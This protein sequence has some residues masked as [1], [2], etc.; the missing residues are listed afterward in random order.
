MMSMLAALVLAATT[1]LTPEAFIREIYADR[2]A[3]DVV[4]L[5][6]YCDPSLARLLQKDE[7]C[8]EKTGEVTNLDFVPILDAQ[9]IDDEGVS[10]LVIKQISDTVYDVSFL[11]FPNDP[12][13]K[14]ELQYTLVHTRK[15]WRIHDIRYWA[16][17]KTLREILSKP[18]G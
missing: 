14:R 9:D 7:E 6:R 8:S 15:G 10:R 17:R 3:E 4:Y 11:L 13:S 12:N 18:C 2:K 5:E 16:S 1:A